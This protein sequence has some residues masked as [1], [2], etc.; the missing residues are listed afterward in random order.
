MNPIKPLYKDT[1]KL[2]VQI[3]HKTKEILSQYAKYTKHSESQII[4]IIAAEILDDDKEFL[5][6]LGTRRYKKKIQSLLSINSKEKELGY[7]EVK[8]TSPFK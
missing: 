5:Q 1:I 3:S 2:E 8:E 6:W 7:A 4:D